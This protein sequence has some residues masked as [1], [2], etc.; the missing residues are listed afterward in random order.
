MHRV[1]MLMHFGITPYIVFDGDYL[2][3]KAST[4]VARAEKRAESKRVG[5]ELYRMG[6]LSQAHLELQKAV[7]VTPEMA[8]QLIEELKRHDVKY[9]VAPYEAD[10]QL[11]FLE[12]KDIIQGIIS[13]D[14]D[15]LVFGAKR[16]LTKLDQYG[17]C[18]EINRDDFTACRDISL[19]GWSDAEFR[20]MAILSGCDYLANINKMGLKTAYRLV[21]KHKT[22]EKIL[23]II[24]LDGQYRVPPGYL[25][26]FRRAEL[27][28]LHQRVFCPCEKKAVM[29]TGLGPGPQSE[30]LAFVGK[31]VEADIA[32]G[33]ARG[34]LHPMTKEPIIFRTETRPA[35]NKS[36]AATRRQSVDASSDLK[37]KKSIDS[38]FKAQRTPLGELDPNSFTPSPSQQRLLAQN[39]GIFSSSAAPSHTPLLRSTT[40]LPASSRPLMP[41]GGNRTSSIHKFPTSLPHPPKRQRLCEEVSPTNEVLPPLS[42]ASIEVGR[43]RFFTSST[44]DPSP[45]VKRKGKNRLQHKTVN[46]WSDDS[47]DEVML[48]LPDVLYKGDVVIKAPK[49]IVYNDS[50]DPEDYESRSNGTLDA[51]MSPSS[52][53]TS[54]AL[55]KSSVTISSI[56]TPAISS[57]ATG[58][59]SIAE[60]DQIETNRQLFTMLAKEPLTSHLS[61]QSTVSANAKVKVPSARNNVSRLLLN[62][63]KSTTALQRLGNNALTRPHLHSER[64]SSDML[65]TASR[66]TS[67]MQSLQ[68]DVPKSPDTLV[69]PVK[70]SEDLLV[71][72]SDDEVDGQ[73]TMVSEGTAKPKLNLGRFVYDG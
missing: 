12:G 68:R 32:L 24:Q 20:R 5:L 22:I 59:K 45:S 43:S 15:M 48:G 16:L 69:I 39:T 35:S 44:P 53:L 58:S 21:R 37:P 72:S 51:N 23:R 33:V 1:R 29:A 11:V 28:F 66:A 70:G 67:N 2:P 54:S 47:I 40:S 61:K 17:D 14:S 30:D 4:E 27:T 64:T 25:E 9:L 41:A 6:K 55:V 38:F 36:W 42:S 34:D 7:D 31:H 10:A 57:S 62:Q 19:V 49:L 56:S 46:I 50:Q 71:A 52:M 18:I 73:P 63:R 13:E 3:S 8:R 60:L 26:N 65:T